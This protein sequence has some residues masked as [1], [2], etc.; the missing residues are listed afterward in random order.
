MTQRNHNNSSR[1]SAIS[2]DRN[3]LPL[4]PVTLS[5]SVPVPIAVVSRRLALFPLRLSPGSIAALG[6]VSVAVPVVFSLYSFL[7]NMIAPTIAARSRTD[8]T[9]KGSAYVVRS[10]RP[11]NG[12]VSGRRGGPEMAAIPEVDT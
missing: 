10:A 11:R 9:S 2:Q 12:A 6:S 8:T 4:F 1:R 7:A 5:V 3:H